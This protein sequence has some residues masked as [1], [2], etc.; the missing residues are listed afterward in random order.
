MLE[1]ILLFIIVAINLLF[2]II[3]CYFLF[4]N[5][6]VKSFFKQIWKNCFAKTRIDHLEYRN[7]AQQLA[8]VLNRLSYDVVGGLIVIEQKN[9]LSDYVK[10]GYSVQAKFSSEFTTNI[11]YNKSSPLHDGGM[12]VRKNEII[13]V[14]SYFPVTKQHLGSVFG[15]R[16]RAALGISEVTDALAFV[17][18]ETSGNIS[19]ARK[20]ELT[21]L[22]KNNQKLANQIYDL[23]LNKKSLNTD[24]DLIIH[25]TLEKK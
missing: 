8:G 13:S 5:K 2:L 1:R 18:S 7:F 9:D 3:A 12:I 10:L 22:S 21:A 25:N 14:A 4:T 24:I 17:V 20:G 15:A 6:N 11:F 19:C 23:L 16:H